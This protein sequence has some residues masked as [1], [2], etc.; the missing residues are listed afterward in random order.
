MIPKT[1]KEVRQILKDENEKRVERRIKE[2]YKGFLIEYFDYGYFSAENLNDCDADI[3]TAKSVQK[4]KIEIDEL[5][6]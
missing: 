3:L 4:L 2:T 1:I 6:I 5:S